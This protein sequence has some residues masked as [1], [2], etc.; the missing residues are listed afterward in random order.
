MPPVHPN[1]IPA[2]AQTYRSTL[3]LLQKDV[4]ESSIYRQ[5]LEALTQHR[6][7]ILDKTKEDD[8]LA[9]EKDIGQ[10]QIEELIEAAERELALVGKM[11]EWKA[12]VKLILHYV[13]VLISCVRTC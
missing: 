12:S 5:S 8:V 6:L 3:A 2:L 7:S 4:P 1:P 11:I 9:V 10:G 13:Y